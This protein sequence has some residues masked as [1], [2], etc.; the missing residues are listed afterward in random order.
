ML[1]RF[2]EVHSLALQQTLYEMGKAALEAH[3]EV[4]EIRFSAPNMHHFVYD[5][6]PFGLDNPNEVFHADDRPYGLIEATV[7]RDDA[8]PAGPGLGAPRLP[9]VWPRPLSCDPTRSRSGVPA[10]PLSPGLDEEDLADL[11]RRLAADDAARRQAYPG[12][13]IRRQ[14]VHTVYVPADQFHVEVAEEWGAAAGAALARYAP[15][16]EDMAQATGMDVDALRH[17]LGRR[18]REAGD[19]AD[20]GPAHRPGGRLRHPAG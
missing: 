7:L 3:E 17:G 2:A 9:A 19:R 11:D 6:S 10:M 15:Q 5:L 18:G 8:P 13:S 14:P 4:A 12:P 1:E 16:P 20:R